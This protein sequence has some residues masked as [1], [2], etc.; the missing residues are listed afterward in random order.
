MTASEK[1]E[2]AEREYIKAIATIKDIFDIKRG[3]RD[4]STEYGNALHNFESAVQGV[5]IY[6]E[7]TIGK[8][9]VNAEQFMKDNHISGDIFREINSV[10]KRRLFSKWKRL[11]WNTI[12]DSGIDAA[13]LS[14]IVKEAVSV[15]VQNFVYP[16]GS[17]DADITAKDYASE[18]SEHIKRFIQAF[19]SPEIICGETEHNLESVE[20]TM[21]GITAG[22]KI[23]NDAILVHWKGGKAID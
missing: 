18:V 19:C 15:S 11:D 14:E 8:V 2:L 12:F 16:L 13:R 7:L 17:I 10:G 21:D 22:I 5:L 9:S 6:V 3:S 23:F 20:K 4:Y 1:V